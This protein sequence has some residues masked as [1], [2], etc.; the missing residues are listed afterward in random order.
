MYKTFAKKTWAAA[1]I[2]GVAGVS[3]LALAASVFSEDFG[4]TLAGYASGCERVNHPGEACSSSLD[5]TVFQSAPQSVHLVGHGSGFSAPFDGVAAT[6]SRSVSLANG[7]YVLDY[8]A[9]HTTRLY[10]FCGGG[11]GGETFIEVNGVAAPSVGCG[12]GGS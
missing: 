2:I 5:T 10:A 9:R 3:S 1:G 8:M 6:L 12:I 11:T 7:V 4:G